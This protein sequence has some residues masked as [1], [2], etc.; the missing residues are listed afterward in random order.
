MKGIRGFTLIELMIV[1][2][3]IAILASIAIPIFANVTARSR[4]AKAQ[5]DVRSLASSVSAYAAH[6]GVLPNA[7]NDLT[8]PA[9]NPAGHTAGQFLPV[10]PA[11]PN[12]NWSTYG[13]ATNANGL[14]TVSA[15]GDNV[16]ISAP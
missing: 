13:Y 9:V 11:P 16:T 7:L 6:M 8:L 12:T 10:I 4:I 2:A 1:V 3:I 14:F 15:A 5:A